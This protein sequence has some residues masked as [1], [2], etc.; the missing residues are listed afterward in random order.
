MSNWH[1][2]KDNLVKDMLELAKHR[3]YPWTWIAGVSMSIIASLCYY[4]SANLVRVRNKIKQLQQQRRDQMS[5]R[6]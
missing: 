2:L 4:D 3:P 6:G 1:E 5:K